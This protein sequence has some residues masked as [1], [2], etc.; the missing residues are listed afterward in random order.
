MTSVLHVL[1]YAVLALLGWLA[2]VLL[3]GTLINGGAWVWARTREAGV[4]LAWRLRHPGGLPKVIRLEPD[5]PV[6]FLPAGWPPSHPRRRSS[7][8]RW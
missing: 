3:L 4:E 1:F 5:E 8:G 2:L 6:T 7:S